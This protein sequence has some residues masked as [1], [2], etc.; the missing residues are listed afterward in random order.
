MSRISI[1]TLLAAVAVAIVAA[2]PAIA[3]AHKGG[4]ARPTAKPVGTVASFSDGTLVI[5]SGGLPVSGRVTF[6]TRIRWADRG[7]HRG[8]EKRGRASSGSR[9]RGSEGGMPT[10]GGLPTGGGMPTG[11]GLP[12][13]RPR[14]TLADLVP[15]AVVREAQLKLTPAGPVWV[16]V[17][18]VRPPVT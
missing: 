17:K 2:I 4:D 8:W 10:A 9:H 5:S 13:R 12:P 14:P 15:G 3:V 18:L 7:R 1:R 16:E 11:G 6:R